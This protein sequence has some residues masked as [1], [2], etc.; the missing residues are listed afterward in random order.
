MYVR[1]LESVGS[2]FISMSG[3]SLVGTN[4]MDLSSISLHGSTNSMGYVKLLCTSDGEWSIVTSER[5]TVLQRV[6]A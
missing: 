6:S 1:G 3:V 2:V 5:L 4:V